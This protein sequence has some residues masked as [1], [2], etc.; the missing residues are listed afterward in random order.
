MSDKN[1]TVQAKELKIRKGYWETIQ[2]LIGE[3]RRTSYNDTLVH[4][5]RNELNPDKVNIDM[6]E[7]MFSAIQTMT[8]S[9]IDSINKK[10]D[11]INLLINDEQEDA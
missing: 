6:L 7:Y 2:N 9:K 3:A 8:H 5:R 11:A 10:L 1:L 4:K